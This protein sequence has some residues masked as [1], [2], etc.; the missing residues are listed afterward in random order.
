MRHYIGQRETIAPHSE[1]HSWTPHIIHTQGHSKTVMLCELNSRYITCKREKL[2]I[3]SWFIDDFLNALCDEM[4]Q[5]DLSIFCL[6]NTPNNILS[7]PGQSG[8][9]IFGTE[10][11]YTVLI[12]THID[13]NLQEFQTTLQNGE[14]LNKGKQIVKPN[15]FRPPQGSMFPKGRAPIKVNPDEFR[16]NDIQS[17]ATMVKGPKKIKTANKSRPRNTPPQQQ[18]MQI[19]TMHQQTNQNQASTNQQ[20]QTQVSS[21][22]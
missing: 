14:M 20:I 15:Y 6:N 22:T 21:I 7:F 18:N 10:N 2:K 1:K 9:I 13:T 11:T 12:D 3:A 5:K 16:P 17:W 8:T 4:D 19:P